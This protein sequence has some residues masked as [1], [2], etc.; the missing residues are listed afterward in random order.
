[1]GV[2]WGSYNKYALLGSVR[3]AFGS[4]TFEACFMCVV[5]L[6]ALVVGKYDI[7]VLMENVW[8]SIFVLPGCYVL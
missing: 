5:V 3:S 1:M 4:V 8:L 2:G 6:L 7:R